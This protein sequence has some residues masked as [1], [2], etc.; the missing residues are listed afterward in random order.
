VIPET[1]V[2]SALKPMRLDWDGAEA[3]EG[4][5]IRW[6]VRH[7]QQSRDDWC[8]AACVRHALSCF[9]QEVADLDV[10]RSV[11]PAALDGG[12]QRIPPDQ[13]LDVW[14]RR[15]FDRARR[16][17]DSI[18]EPDLQREL[19]EHGPVEL[20]LWPDTAPAMRHLVLVTGFRET[21]DAA[22]YRVSDPLLAADDVLVSYGALRA[23]LP[24][25]RWRRTY[26]GLE[27]GGGALR[28]FVYHPARFLA[29]YDLAPPDPAEGKPEFPAY[30][31][32]DFR[33]RVPPRPAY[34]RTE[35]T[36]AIHGLRYWK[37]RKG[38]EREELRR[39]LWLGE[40]L[41]QVAPAAPLDATRPLA[42]QWTDD[43]WAS[44]VYTR[45]TASYSAWSERRD[46]GEWYSSWV[47]RTWARPLAAG[48]RAV[49]REAA[50]GDELQIARARHGRLC[51]IRLVESDRYLVAHVRGHERPFRELLSGAEI[52]ERLCAEDP[53]AIVE[54][55][56]PVDDAT[57]NA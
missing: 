57:W 36:A 13:I 4:D 29:R 15:G 31:T 37:A 24:L 6:R 33:L 7:R 34:L 53:R 51:L 2:L 19:L 46:D 56:T 43:G 22:L 3:A 54:G 20:E 47:G 44:L 8:W 50:G 26:C 35:V 52:A 40:S 55:L 14:R 39:T 23:Q 32:S 17:D 25:G 1:T 48:L 16:V 18:A 41:A 12:D 30:S 38:G 9:G 45:G 27:H 5:D 28:R 49:A 21:P 42:G 11:L 10:V